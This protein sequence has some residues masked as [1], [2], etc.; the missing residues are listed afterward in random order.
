MAG[1][2][3]YGTDYTLGGPQSQIV[4]PAGQ[5]SAEIPLHALVDGAHER[6]ET[7]K[8]K[9]SAGVGYGVPKRAGKTA[10]IKI[11]NVQ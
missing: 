6:G 7:V 3:R 4:I 11:L 2:A 9:L 8:L 1:S 10:T 5:A